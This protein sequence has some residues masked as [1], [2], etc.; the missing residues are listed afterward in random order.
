MRITTIFFLNVF[1]GFIFSQ[2]ALSNE[3]LIDE[4]LAG[5]HRDV[6]FIKRD[7]YRHPKETLEFFNITPEKSVV[8]I[9][10]GY[11]WYAEILAPLLQEN[12]NYIYASYKLNEGINP[13]FIKVEKAATPKRV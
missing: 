1:L 8:E 5:D 7:K 11:G 4:V 6:N 2:P 9:T 13:F 12:G 3:N 10:P